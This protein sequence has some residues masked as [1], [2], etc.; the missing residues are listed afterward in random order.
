MQI[1]LALSCV[2]VCVCVC[3]CGQGGVCGCWCAFA[4]I[5]G[6][7]QYKLMVKSSHVFRCQCSTKSVPRAQMEF[8]MKIHNN[9]YC[10]P[11]SKPYV[12]TTY[13]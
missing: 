6:G 4:F 5:T 3:V 12:D 2:S 9:I 8:F 13:L 10:T 7:E 11:I 1:R